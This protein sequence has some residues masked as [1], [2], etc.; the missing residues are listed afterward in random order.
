[1][2]DNFETPYQGAEIEAAE[3]GLQ[4][5]LGVAELWVIVAMQG[6]P[7][8][9]VGWDAHLRVTRLRQAEARKLFCSIAGEE[10]A[11]DPD[12]DGLLEPLDG[13]ARAVDLMAHQ[14]QGHLTLARL[15][16]RWVDEHH[17][18][19][20]R[21]TGRSKDHSMAVTY[22]VALSHA[23]LSDETREV[24]SAL[25]APPIGLDHA[26]LHVLG[27]TAG[28]EAVTLRNL[29]LL[30]A[31]G[32]RYRLLSPLRQY[33]LDER[34]G[35]Q[36][37]LVALER[38][39]CEF[40]QK[41]GMG[42]GRVGGALAA[43]S[44]LSELPNLEWA[45]RE[46][47][48]RGTEVDLAVGAGGGVA[49]F[50]RFAGV[51]GVDLLRWLSEQ[52]SVR[53]MA[54]R[55]ANCELSLGNILLAR[56]DHE[57]ARK[58]YE[59]ALPLYRGVR[60]RLGEANCERSLGD[61]LLRRSDHERAQKQ[62]EK[63]QSLYREVG[64]KVGEAACEKSLGDILLERGDHERAQKQYEKAQPLYREMGVKLG[65]AVCEQR[66][67]D[68]LLERGDHER[69][70]KQYEKA[71]PLYRD[72]GAKL[73][74]A[75]CEQRLGDIL[76]ARSDHEGAR[77]QYEKALPL[78]RAVGDKLGEANCEQGVGDTLYL[79]GDHVGGRAK[80]LAALTRYS[81]IAEPYSM[82]NAHARLASVSEAA[83]RRE[84][85][86]EAKRLCQSI[87]RPDLVEKL[88]RDFPDECEEI[89]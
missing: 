29:S 33:L 52:D 58:Q 22:E 28:D 46:A 40:A 50:S 56:S 34:P 27:P 57:G 25:A 87:D 55:W 41:K 82:A 61:L 75:A 23:R 66:L 20:S 78:Y 24:L 18:L 69:A 51:G 13:V 19:L 4:E 72:V 31:E 3:R 89:A 71:Q 5:L 47:V 2:L 1:M 37:H 43:A 48:R 67:G 85:V 88:C 12:L 83:E 9:A 74:E 53:M 80:W 7:P 16:Q 8:P 81:E 60:D 64:A 14:A 62:Y 65:E 68:I 6:E 73:G 32:T 77:K 38:H 59:K 79:T 36:K 54:V 17:R 39:Y 70:R 11:A 30:Y 49:E 76:L 42:M 63:A 44:M 10:F 35:Q 21:G 84:H 45:V 26:H 86:Q 15:R